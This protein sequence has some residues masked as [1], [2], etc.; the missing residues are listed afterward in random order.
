ML[1]YVGCLVSKTAAQTIANGVASSLSFDE[2]IHDTDAFHSNTVSPERITIPQGLAGTYQ[3]YGSVQWEAD[4]TNLRYTEIRVNGTPIARTA[5]NTIGGASL[6]QNI[7]VTYALAVA[8]IV[9]L[10]VY[11]NSGG[12]LDVENSDD[13]YTPL[14]GINLLGT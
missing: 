12:G 10:Y 7:S 3:I 6:T 4:A 1:A 11:Q 9:T 2:E 5:H 8:D 13:P 14:F